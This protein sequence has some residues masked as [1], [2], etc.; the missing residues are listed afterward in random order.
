LSSAVIQLR[1]SVRAKYLRLVVKP[2]V[3]ELVV[4]TGISEA[5]ARAFLE[6]HRA[7]LDAQRRKMESRVA[8]QPAFGAFTAYPTIPW[9]GRELPLRVLDAPGKRPRVK[10]DEAVCIT[11][12]QGLDGER[13]AAARNAFE[14]WTRRWLPAEITRLVERHA[15]RRGL[16]PRVIRVKSMRTRWGSCGPRRDVNINWLLALAPES[17]L[18]YVVVHELC[19]IRERNHSP[20]FWA[21]VAEHLP[22]WTRERL[23]LKAHGAEL[24]RR[25][26]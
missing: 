3:T 21:L 4:P 23:W 6:R 10:V 9:R 20:A 1:R 5:Q 15:P 25:F 24:L 12:P 26:L 16:H 11:L 8:S 7:W 22:N 19:H 2:E 14:G 17:V 18:E 13:D